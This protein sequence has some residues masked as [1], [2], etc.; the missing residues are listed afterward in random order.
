MRVGTSVTTDRP[1]CS[2]EC[3]KRMTVS[4]IESVAI[5]GLGYVGRSLAKVFTKAGFTVLGIDISEVKVRRLR[6]GYSPITDVSDEDVV[7]MLSGG[8]EPTT[9]F[10][11]V[12]HSSAVIFALPTP[13]D[14]DKKPDLN[15]LLS[16]VRAA[17]VHSRAGQLLIVESTVYPGVTE[18]PVVDTFLSSAPSEAADFLLAYS[19]ERIDPGNSN[20]DLTS[21]PKIVAG[22]ESRSASAAAELYRSVGFDVVEASSIKAAETAK[23]LENTYRAVNLALV[24]ELVRLILPGDID[25]REVVRLSETKPFGFEAFWPG[26]G[27]GGHC[28]PVDPW[29][30]QAFLHD[31]GKASPLVD[32]ALSIN[33]QMPRHTA[34]Q[35]LSVG[36][37]AGLLRKRKSRINLLGMTYKADVNDFRD[38]PGPEILNVL[39]RQGV[40]VFYHDPFLNEPLSGSNGSWISGAIHSADLEGMTVILQNHRE[41]FEHLSAES[42][43]RRVYSAAAGR[44]QIGQSIWG[45]ELCDDTEPTW[46]KN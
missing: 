26:P 6:Q 9:A 44:G 25:F 22:R 7:E 34:Q 32:L 13:L 28:I 37:Q 17:A 39:A 15:P 3:E 12:S 31:Q 24:N 35:I 16:A 40:E 43:P 38:S 8:F 20:L 5:V 1:D 42:E 19:P 14:Q 23:L 18:G 30:L 2:K 33:S 36:L 21:I 4:A 46:A 27:V 11:S 29:Y 45:P 41:Y 10:H